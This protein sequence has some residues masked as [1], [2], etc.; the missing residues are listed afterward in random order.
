MTASKREEQIAEIRRF[1]R[2][3]AAAVS[4]LTADQLTT[5]YLPDEWTVAQIVH[6]IAD[7]H[8]N[9]YVRCKLMA[10]EEHPALRAYDEKRW[11][12]LSDAASADLEY[13][14][15]LLNA[16]HERWAIFWQSLTDAD[17]QRSGVHSADGE[18]TLADQLALYVRHG[19]I[20]LQQIID[21]LAAG[22]VS[23]EV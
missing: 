1:P 3:L 17:W 11:A 20:H 8:M 4:Q 6:H 19:R 5:A 21:T 12:E 14:L 7:S 22:G 18:V 10:T 13:S 2:V 15:S 23:V 9:S 16:L